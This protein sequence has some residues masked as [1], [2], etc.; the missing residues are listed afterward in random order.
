[1][2]GLSLASNLARLGTPGRHTRPP[3]LAAVRRACLA[4]LVLLVIQY[5]IGVF[6]NLYVAVPASDKGAGLMHEIVTAPF[7]LSLHA[8]VGVALV[9]VAVV[10]LART[11]ALRDSALIALAALALA[12]ICGAFLAGESF[13]SSGGKS[14]ES[15]A[16]AALTGVALVCY[17]GTLGLTGQR[18]RRT[19]SEQE[20]DSGDGSAPWPAT[21]PWET[22]PPNGRPRPAWPPRR[23]PPGPL[24]RRRGYPDPALRESVLWEPTHREWP[25]Q[26][27]SWDQ[28]P[29]GY[30]PYTSR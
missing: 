11:V 18:R 23:P 26:A 30:P 6:L 1:M 25:R 7:A 20:P 9:G 3:G 28:E 27:A 16:M 19:I 15:F 29:D 22:G 14:S 4:V 10:V 5:D 12:S 24:P 13:V 21:R 8:T 17:V 2:R